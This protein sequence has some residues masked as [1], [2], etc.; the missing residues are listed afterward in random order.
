[1]RNL[2]AFLK[3]QLC[4]G[5]SRIPQTDL[6]EPLDLNPLRQTQ[7]LKRSK[8]GSLGCDQTWDTDLISKT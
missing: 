5:V 7:L 8:G 6:N 2:E 1:M 3:I 4:G